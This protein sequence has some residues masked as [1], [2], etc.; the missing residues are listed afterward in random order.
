MSDNF[1]LY[2]EDV[3]MYTMRAG[4][5][6]ELYF[7]NLYRRKTKSLSPSE[8]LLFREKGY[9]GKVADYYTT[10]DKTPCKF[11]SNTIWM[12]VR[13]DE[14]MFRIFSEHIAKTVQK[15]LNAAESLTEHFI[16]CCDTPVHLNEK[17]GQ[18]WM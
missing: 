18:K 17:E 9:S 13:D 3:F 10:V 12:K 7:G 1:E 6:I 2:K 5:P 11:Y 4:K 8:R 15:H 14:T 16:Y